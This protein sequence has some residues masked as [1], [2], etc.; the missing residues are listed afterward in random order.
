VSSEAIA[1][2]EPCQPYGR[3]GGQGSKASRCLIEIEP[4]AVNW[5]L[6]VCSS[7]WPEYAPWDH[8]S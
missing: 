2:E 4:V 5:P 3:D 8:A 1:L 7:G 6:N